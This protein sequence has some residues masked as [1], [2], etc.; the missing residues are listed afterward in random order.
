MKTLL[1]RKFVLVVFCLLVLPATALADHT[2]IGPCGA[3]FGPSMV[4]GPC[5]LPGGGSALYGSQATAGVNSFLNIHSPV[6]VLGGPGQVN[7]FMM[8]IGSGPTWTVFAPVP[9]L[10]SLSGTVNI[11][12]PGASVNIVFT[13]ELGGPPV[14]IVA[15]FTENTVFSLTAFGNQSIFDIDEDVGEIAVAVSRLVIT[16]NGAASFTGSGEFEGAIPEPA[17]LL[18]LGTGLAGV[19][20]K[21]RKR[22]KIRKSKQ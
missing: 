9:T 17:T 1:Q 19:A 13:G 11:F 16:I 2:T 6:V 12:E 18:L 14:S 10:L 21:T 3:V 15:N 22:L 8:S 7:V 4:F 20:I 5:A